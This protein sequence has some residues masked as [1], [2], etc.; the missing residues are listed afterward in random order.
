MCD[1]LFACSLVEGLHLGRSF[2]L[3]HEMGHKAPGQ[4]FTAD[5]QCAYFW[6]RDYKV[7]IPS[8]RS[9]ERVN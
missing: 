1:Q 4:R 2:V 8:G 6:G 3:A 7:E 5:Q 9:M